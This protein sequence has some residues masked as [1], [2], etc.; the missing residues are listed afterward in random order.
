MAIVI[1]ILPSITARE[2]VAAREKIVARLVE[3]YKSGA[4]E[5]ASALE[6]VRVGLG[7]KYDLPLE[8]IARFEMGNSLAIMVNT[9]PATL[10][11]LIAIHA[12]PGL[13][14][15]IREEVDACTMTSVEEDGQPKRHIDLARLRESCPLLLSTWQETIRCNS[16]GTSVRLVKEDTYLEGMLLKKGAMLQMPSR[17]IHSSSTLWGSSAAEFNPR[18]FL[19]SEKKHRPGDKYF[20]GFGGG[21][22]LCPGR[23]FAT[24]EGLAM[25]AAFVARLD[26]DPVGGEWVLPTTDNTSAATTILEPDHDVDVEIRVRKGMENTRWDLG[27]GGK[28]SAFSLFTEEQD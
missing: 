4:H 22:H 1:G 6:R 2:P 17:T 10:W 5:Q 24:N 13:R 28:G 21:K 3:Y 16:M 12:H 8:D 27:L 23:H 14:N 18:R 15:Q 7:K 25:V 26:M 11:A 9:G 19:P 20:R